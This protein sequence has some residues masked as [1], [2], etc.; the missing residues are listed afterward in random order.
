MADG[1]CRR[2][3]VQR[4][5]GNAKDRMVASGSGEL[6]RSHHGKQYQILPG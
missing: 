3:R 2:V 6:Y 5:K 4:A 1:F